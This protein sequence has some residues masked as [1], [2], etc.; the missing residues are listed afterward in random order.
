VISN[1]GAITVPVQSGPVS[2]D[3]QGR[4]T[5]IVLGQPLELGQLRLATFPAGTRLEASGGN[6]LRSNQVATPV[7]PGAATAQQGVIEGSNVQPPLEMSRLADI[8]RSY[9]FTAKMMK[10]ISGADDLNKLAG[11]NDQ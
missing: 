3:T 9:E 8:K 4:V 11:A 1:G 7:Q 5:T 10:E 6:L 2:I